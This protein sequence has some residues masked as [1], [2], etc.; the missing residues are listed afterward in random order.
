MGLGGREENRPKNA[1]FFRGKRYDNKILNL[2]ILFSRN[3]VV[4]A[5]APKIIRQK[6]HREFDMYVFQRVC[7][8]FGQ[9]SSCGHTAVASVCN[10]PLQ[11]M[12][13]GQWH[14]S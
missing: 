2:Q 1:F 3:F 12:R 5:Q 6:D 13:E 8:S 14:F 10:Q 11:P 9:D 7:G 4:I